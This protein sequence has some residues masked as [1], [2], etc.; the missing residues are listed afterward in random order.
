M[1]Y[2]YEEF[3][4]KNYDV[5]KVYK[6]P[7]L[8]AKRGVESL[9][10]AY[11]AEKL[12]R[13]ACENANEVISLETPKEHAQA[14]LCLKEW[15]ILIEKKQ[16]DGIISM[17]EINAATIDAYDAYLTGNETLEKQVMKWWKCQDPAFDY[18]IRKK[19]NYI[20]AGCAVPMIKKSSSENRILIAVGCTHLLGK[21]GVPKLLQQQLGNDYSVVNVMMRG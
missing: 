1:E 18:Y 14:R 21:H 19:R 6:Y 15:E 7:S 5:T 13:E 17:E 3:N 11:G 4:K 2:Y 20:F 16:R 9:D 10:H 12:I 8:S